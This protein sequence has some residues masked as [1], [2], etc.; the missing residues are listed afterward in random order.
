[1]AGGGEISGTRTFND[2]GKHYLDVLLQGVPD[3]KL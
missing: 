2:F 3:L 1:M